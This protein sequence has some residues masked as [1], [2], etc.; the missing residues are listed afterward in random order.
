MNMKNKSKKASTVDGRES[1][2]GVHFSISRM[3]EA[4]HGEKAFRLLLR[5]LDFRLVGDCEIVSGDD[6]TGSD[7][8]IIAFAGLTAEAVTYIEK[9]VC[10]AWRIYNSGNWGGIKDKQEREAMYSLGGQVHQNWC[11]VRNCVIRESK[12]DSPCLFHNGAFKNGVITPDDDGFF[13]VVLNNAAAL[14]DRLQAE[15]KQGYLSR[16]ATS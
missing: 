14:R 11:V 1:S 10:K 8:Y 5:C 4:R 15:A 2:I 9:R 12:G 3:N 6:L 7:T 16:Q 13:G